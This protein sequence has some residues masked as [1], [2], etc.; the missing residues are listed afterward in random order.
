[1]NEIFGTYV[2]TMFMY[3]YIRVYDYMGSCIA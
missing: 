1:M 2:Y 3:E